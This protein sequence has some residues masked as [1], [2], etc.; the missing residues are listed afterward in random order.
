MKTDG[1]N[2]RAFTTHSGIKRTPSHNLETGSP[3]PTEQHERVDLGGTPAPALD[4]TG[5]KQF[6]DEVRVRDRGASFQFPD[7]LEAPK[8][9]GDLPWVLGGSPPDGES[10]RVTTTVQPEIP[11]RTQETVTFEA[12]AGRLLGN[13]PTTKPNFEDFDGAFLRH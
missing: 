1:L 8:R 6:A 4:K 2:P 3:N 12:Q 11:T 5:Q 9:E 7:Q 13:L 10:P